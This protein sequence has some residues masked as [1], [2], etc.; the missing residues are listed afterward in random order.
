MAKSSSNG[1]TPKR[2]ELQ[3]PDFNRNPKTNWTWANDKGL[4]NLNLKFESDT[5]G[6]KPGEYKAPKEEI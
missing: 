5:G 6:T 3:F 2:Y 4:S 1:D